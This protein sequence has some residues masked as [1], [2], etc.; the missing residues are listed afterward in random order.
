MEDTSGFSNCESP[1]FI[2]RYALAAVN[3]AAPL[4]SSAAFTDEEYGNDAY[5]EGLGITTERHCNWVMVACFDGSVVDLTFDYGGRRSGTLATEIGLLRNLKTIEMSA[6]GIYGSIPSEIGLLSD[7]RVLVMTNNFLT[8]TIPTEIGKLT[9]LQRL[10]LDMNGDFLSQVQVGISGTLPKEIQSLTSLMILS[11]HGNSITGSIPSEIGKLSNLTG[12]T[13]YINSLTGTIPTE[14]GEL[15]ELQQ[16]SLAYNLLTGTIP[17]ELGS[18]LSDNLYLDLQVNNLTGSV[19]LE[20]LANVTNKTVEVHGNKLSDLTPVDGSQVCSN[21]EVQFSIG[22]SI[23]GGEHYCNCRNDCFEQPPHR[24]NKCT[25]EGGQACC[26]SLRS[27]IPECIICEAGLS[28]PDHRP[29]SSSNELRLTCGEL[30]K[31]DFIQLLVYTGESPCNETKQFFVEEFEC[32][33]NEDNSTDTIGELI[34]N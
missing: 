17:S 2:E 1:D 9:R 5:N 30:V 26:N 7:L 32:F 20:L 21:N 10:S 15:Q 29:D 33:C 31:V 3:F 14:I 16:L 27:Q 12:F 24:P 4:N 13:L 19:P 8:G 34:L 22:Y 11:L 28:N 23:N 6:Q 25:C 18:V